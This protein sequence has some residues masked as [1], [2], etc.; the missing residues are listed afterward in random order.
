MAKMKC[1]VAAVQALRA[2]GVRRGAWAAYN[3]M[4]LDEMRSQC[5]TRWLS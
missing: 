3:G 2:A 4:T 1:G 5:Q